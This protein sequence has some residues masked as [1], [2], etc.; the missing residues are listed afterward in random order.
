MSR[1]IKTEVKDLNVGGRIKEL[2]T[3]RGLTFITE[4]DRDD[5]SQ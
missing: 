1:D 5:R 3:K 2:R 4:R